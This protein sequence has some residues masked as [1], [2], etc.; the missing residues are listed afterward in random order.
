VRQELSSEEWVD[1][2][3]F[4]KPTISKSGL[5]DDT[6]GEFAEYLSGVV[7]SAGHSGQCI[8]VPYGT[9]GQAFYRAGVPTVVFGPGSI[10]QAHTKDEWIEL[11]QLEAAAELY[12]Q[13]ILQFGA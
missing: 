12:Y 11:Q 10:D 5:N 13:M 3:T 7:Q 8:G 9:D 6:N 4:H 1:D 2:I